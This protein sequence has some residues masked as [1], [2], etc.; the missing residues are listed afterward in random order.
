M[1]S[2]TDEVE[3]MVKNLTL[4]MNLA[5]EGSSWGDVRFNVAENYIVELQF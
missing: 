5:T 2:V 1:R 4:R 3:S